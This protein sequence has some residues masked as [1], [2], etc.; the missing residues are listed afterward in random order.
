LFAL[1]RKAFAF[2]TLFAA[3]LWHGAECFAACGQRQGLL[4]LDLGSIFDKIAASKN[5]YG[6][7]LSCTYNNFSN[8]SI[9][10]A[11]NSFFALEI[12]SL[13]KIFNPSYNKKQ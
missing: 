7:G 5:F 4:A 13:D 6:L 10:R 2:L 8:L 1:P 12:L 3:R 11:F 9:L